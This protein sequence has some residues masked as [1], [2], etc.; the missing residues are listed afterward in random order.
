MKIPFL[1]ARV[2]LTSPYGPRT[3]VPGTSGFHGGVDL[4]GLDS[5]SVVSVIS[6]T[7]A[8]S[9]YITDHSNANWMWGQHIIIAGDD[10]KIYMYFHLSERKV[11]RFERV[12]AGQVIGTMGN[13]GY[14]FGAHLHFEVREGDAA[15]RINS[16]NYLGIPNREGIYQIDRKEEE[17]MTQEEFGAMFDKMRNEPTGDEHA[18]WSDPFVYWAKSTGLFVSDGDGNY[19]WKSPITREE[20]ATVLYR[21]FNMIH[22]A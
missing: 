5:W 14:S 4:V 21:F 1:G 2:R 20:L 16:A 17:E 12:D 8:A 22:G 3:D 18:E 9:D 6:G 11:Q 7:V 10:G 13:T 15:T 19:R